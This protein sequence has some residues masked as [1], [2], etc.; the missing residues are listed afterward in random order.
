MHD[1]DNDLLL[2]T[3]RTQPLEHRWEDLG[4]ASLQVGG[5]GIAVPSS[6]HMVF[7]EIDAPLNLFGR[8]NKA[9]FR[10]PLLLAVFH[11]I[12]GD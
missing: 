12:D 10:V 9:F 7:A 5:P 4:A 2:L 3:R 8:L 1:L 11:R 6:P